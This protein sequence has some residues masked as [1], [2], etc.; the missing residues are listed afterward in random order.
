MKSIIVTNQS[1]KKYLKTEIQK[2]P[3]D[4]S[5]TVEIKKTGKDSTAKQRRL[6]WLWCSE[7]AK[8]GVGYDDNKMDVHIRGKYKFALPIL[9][10]DCDI[11]PIIHAHFMEVTRY[12]ED[13]SHLVKE[14][15]RLHISTEQMT[16]EQRAEY[17]TDF[18]QFFISHGVTLTD[19]SLQGL[20]PDTF[21]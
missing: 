6:N 14:F 3:D 13:R 17:L 9:L 21:L 1:S 10:R 20:N 4:G 8:S 16:K 2:L 7:I 11:F 15:T 5:Y 18:S 12:A 19:P